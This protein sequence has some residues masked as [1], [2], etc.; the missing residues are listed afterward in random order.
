MNN[1]T[2]QKFQFSDLEKT[3]ADLT[4]CLFP[5]Y[6]L[7]P[8]N[9][10]QKK[11]SK[12]CI[13]IVDKYWHILS[14]IDWF[15]KKISKYELYF[16]DFYPN[17]NKITH[18]EA[19]EHHI[20]AYLEDM[21]TLKNKLDVF[22]TNLKNDLKKISTNKKEIDRVLKTLRSNIYMAFSSSQ[23]RGAHRHGIDRFVDYHVVKGQL[24]NT[25]LEQPILRDRLT[26]TGLEKLASKRDGSL[27]QGKKW[28]SNNAAN[29]YKECYGLVN[30]VMRRNKDLLYKL[31][32]IEPILPKK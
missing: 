31:L 18:I 27:T 8:Y 13:K 15:V 23:L 30:E 2:V 6:L 12:F 25:F 19:L 20:H 32:D 26:K 21:E 4:A 28:W 10:E 5:E 11:G 16:T 9:T 1:M 14:T 17:G 7:P 3:L 24:A 22:V 29:N